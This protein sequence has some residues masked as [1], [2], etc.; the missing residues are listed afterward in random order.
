MSAFVNKHL[1]A[2]PIWLA[3]GA[4]LLPLAWLVW[5]LLSGGLGVDPVRALEAELGQTG[6]KLIVLGLI[7]SP[8]QRY[9][10][11]RLIRF[12]RAIGL[13]AFFYVTLHM[14]TWLLLDMQLL[15]GQIWKDILKR[16]YITLGMAGFAMMLPL[17]LT[18]NDRII[19]RMGAAAWRRLH[20]LVYPVALAG[21]LHYFL[22]VKGW[23]PEPIVYLAVILGLLGLRILPAMKMRMR[24]ALADSN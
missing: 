10:N 16:P 2:I 22:V 4:G 24:R 1:R 8:L 20:R 11:L 21:A 15:W 7:V 5:R 3:Y 12:R 17:A 13:L 18:S 23:Q 6:L 19:R 14:L 9:A